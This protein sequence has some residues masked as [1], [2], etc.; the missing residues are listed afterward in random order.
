[1]TWCRTLTLVFGI[2]GAWFAIIGT[3]LTRYMILLAAI[4]SAAWVMW[5]NYD[6]NSYDQIKIGRLNLMTWVAWSVGLFAVGLWWMYLSQM[7]DLTFVQR[8]AITAAAWFLVI[9]VIEWIGYNV[10]NI[11]LKSNYPGLFG[12]ELMHGPQYLKVYYLSAWALY[13]FMLNLSYPLQ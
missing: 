10:L 8:L 12:M 6:Y 5:Y 4:M 13:L 2:V 9:T 3:P 1:M 7:T 11:R